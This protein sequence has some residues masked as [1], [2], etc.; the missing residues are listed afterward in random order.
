[1]QPAV[2]IHFSDCGCL[3]LL[4]RPTQ[5]K[6]TYSRLT[7]VCPNFQSSET[8]TAFSKWVKSGSNC[9]MLLK[10]F[11][12]GSVEMGGLF[13]AYELFLRWVSFISKVWRRQSFCGD[14][15][16]EVISAGRARSLCFD[17]I[18]AHG[19][20][21]PRSYRERESF[22]QEM[23]FFADGRVALGCV[24]GIWDLLVFDELFL[25]F[26][27]HPQRGRKSGN[28]GRNHAG[29]IGFQSHC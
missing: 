10:T 20:F 11:F 15:P 9:K 1:M 7:S 13:H 26:E 23:V 29:L 25:P 17:C 8:S 22:H 2:I 28:R 5:E 16:C 12:T 6:E 24:L 14:Q 27:F 21:R 18:F 4:Y 19:L 3:L